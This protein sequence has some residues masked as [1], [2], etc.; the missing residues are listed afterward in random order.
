MS[1]LE[2]VRHRFEWDAGN[3]AAIYKSHSPASRW[4]NRILRRAIF[5]R[6]QISM[7]ELGDVRGR[8]IL[9][10]GCGIGIYSV[11]LARR[12]CRRVVGLDFSELMLE[13]AR[14]AARSARVEGAIEFVRDE[15]LAHDFKGEVFNIA[16]AMGVFDYLE[17]PLP[18]LKKMAQITRGRIL[19][20]FP[21]F[22]ILRGTARRLR[23]RLTNRGDVFYY[24]SNDVADLA[25]AAG[26]KRHRLIR[27]DSSGGGVVLVGDNG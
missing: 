16:I 6:Y 17:Q 27:I 2:E 5:A 18:F 8:S 21:R 9:D 12:G 14:A 25:R 24:S 10:I 22:S 3:F 19:A 23:Y 26:L 4:F 7:Q 20:S 15:F 1:K 11:E 13:M